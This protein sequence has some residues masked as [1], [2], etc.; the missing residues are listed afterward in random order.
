MTKTGSGIFYD[1][2][3][4]RPNNVT[5]TVTPANRVFLTDEAGNAVAS[6]PCDDVR[7][8]DAPPGLLRMR[9][10]TDE[11]ARLE[12][13]DAMLAQTLML[14]CTYLK[15]GDA[16]ERSTT[17][18]IVGWSIAACVSLVLVAVYGVPAIAE[19]L[20]PFIPYAVDQQLGAG[21]KTSLVQ[22][23]SDGKVCKPEPAAQSAFLKV[24]DKLLAHASDLNG[25]VDIVIL[26]S[27]M[28]NAFALPGGHVM[29][30]S[31]LLEGAKSPD[32]VAGVIAHE[33]GHVAGRHSMHKLVAESGLYFLLGIVLGDFSGSTVLIAG[34]RAI[35]NAGY[36]RDAER[37]AD[38]YAI[39]LMARADGDPAAFASML[40]RFSAGS[41]FGVLNILSSHPHTEERVVEIRT[42]TD[43][44]MGGRSPDSLLSE[45]EWRALKTYCANKQ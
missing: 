34:S 13:S 20:V 22:Q 2:Q 15:H 27:S 21:V 35:L 43:D 41:P 28:K 26:P 36:S 39:E 9:V 45:V 29:I 42:I 1:G 33:L 31:A 30:M 32:E 44:R 23:L 37:D 19:R 40:E 4:A 3:S 7:M 14:S 6:W 8:A 18:K 10:Q 11:Q 16:I 12:V 25:S 38:R 5:V 24:K 17:L